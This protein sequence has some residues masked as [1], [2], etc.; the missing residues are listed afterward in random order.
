MGSELD[1]KAILL[2]FLLASI[3]PLF[4]IGVVLTREIAWLI[5]IIINVISSIYLI[6]RIG[7]KGGK[8]FVS[9]TRM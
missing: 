4:I 2:S 7:R 5:V 3:I 8:R 9:E 1:W 6:K